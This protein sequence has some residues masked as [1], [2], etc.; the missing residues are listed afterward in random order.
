MAKQGARVARVV[1][2]RN[3]LFLAEVIEAMLKRKPTK[4]EKDAFDAVFRMGAA[5]GAAAVF[6]GMEKA[7]T[8][9]N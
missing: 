4:K 7:A 1:Y 8:S 3:R 5:T 9:R 6:D 2:D